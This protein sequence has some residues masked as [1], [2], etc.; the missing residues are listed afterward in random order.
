MKGERYLRIVRVDNYSSFKSL[1]SKWKKITI[2]QINLSLL[3]SETY[4]IINGICPPIMEILL[5][6]EKIR[7]TQEIFEKY[8]MKIGKQW[9][10]E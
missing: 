2:H 9:N 5:Y 7:I 6:Y 4:K 10:T 1:L 3:M 8:L